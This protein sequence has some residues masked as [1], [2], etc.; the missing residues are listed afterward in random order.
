MTKRMILTCEIDGIDEAAAPLEAEGWRLV[1]GMIPAM[2]KVDF[3]YGRFDPD[4]DTPARA[5]SCTTQVTHVAI[6]LE[7]SEN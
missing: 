7:L 5:S 2:T 3:T 4:F 1:P 6:M